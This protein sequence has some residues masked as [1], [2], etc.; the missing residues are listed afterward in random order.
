MVSPG[1]ETHLKVDCF[2]GKISPVYGVCF[3]INNL[4]PAIPQWEDEFF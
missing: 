3:E 2:Y 1:L 4:Q